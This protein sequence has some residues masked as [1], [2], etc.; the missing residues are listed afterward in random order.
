[1]RLCTRCRHITPGQPLFCNFCGSTYDVRLCPSRHVNPRA[2][3]FCS[4]CGSRDLSTPAPRL[5]FW[6]IPLANAVSLAPALV[7]TIMSFILLAAFVNAIANSRQIGLMLMIPVLLLGVAWFIYMQIPPF[8]RSLFRTI[9]PRSKKNR[10][11]S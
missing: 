2:A 8:I 10:P 9:W 5:P 11:R 4:A 7:L 1:M 6:I 3:E